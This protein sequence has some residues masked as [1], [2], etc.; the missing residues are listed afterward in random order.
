[1]IF[2]Y[3]RKI[4]KNFAYYTLESVKIFNNFVR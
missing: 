3:N 1:M 4:T 2:K